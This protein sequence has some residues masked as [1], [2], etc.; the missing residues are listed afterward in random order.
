[1]SAANPVPRLSPYRGQ[2]LAVGKNTEV[3]NSRRRVFERL[4]S[5]ARRASGLHRRALAPAQAGLSHLRMSIATYVPFRRSGGARERAAK[6]IA[7]RG[8]GIVS[9]MT[10]Q[11]RRWPPFSIADLDAAVPDPSGAHRASRW[12]HCV[13]ILLA[14]QSGNR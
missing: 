5:V 1:M 2:F 13:E 9:S 14:A 6:K 10:T 4:I 12:P 3:I 8:N 7:G 11:K